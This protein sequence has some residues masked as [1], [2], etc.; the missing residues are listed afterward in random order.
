[1]TEQFGQFKALSSE[2]SAIRRHKAFVCEA[3]G[4]KL[5]G[6]LLDWEVRRD[7]GATFPV[8]DHLFRFLFKP[9]DHKAEA[10]Y[11]K[12]YTVTCQMT[13]SIRLQDTVS[14]LKSKFKEG[15]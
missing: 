7:D 1:V 8:P 5:H 14:A 2:Y 15:S 12:T 6:S 13:E 4:I 3:E 10:M 9:M 11:A